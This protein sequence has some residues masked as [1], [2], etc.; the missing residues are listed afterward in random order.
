V[1]AKEKL[2]NAVNTCL[3][4]TERDLDVAFFLQSPPV[5]SFTELWFQS[6][7][8]PD[9]LTKTTSLPE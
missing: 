5:N 3:A 1:E 6:L 8:P 4:N 9:L 7:D 2:A